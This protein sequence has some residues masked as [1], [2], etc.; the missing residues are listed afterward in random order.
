MFGFV[1]M[2]LFLKLK[3][4]AVVVAVIGIGIVIVMVI[5]NVID[6]FLMFSP[7]SI[8]RIGN[9]HFRGPHGHRA[10]LVATQSTAPTA[11]V[12]A[13]VDLPDIAAVVLHDVA[14]PIKIQTQH[15]CLS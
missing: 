14:V 6:S 1:A 9:H 12:F 13:T 7:A 8:G 10:G 3:C 4:I 5:V 15:A 11:F 2:C